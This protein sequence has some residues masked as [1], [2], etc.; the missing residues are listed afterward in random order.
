MFLQGE[1]VV[2]NCLLCTT[3]PYSM[4]LSWECAL[5]VSWG[6]DRT[7]EYRACRVS[8]GGPVVGVCAAFVARVQ[9]ELAVSPNG[10]P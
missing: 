5:R 1:L 8:A 6:T 3:E 10:E 2:N 7:C 9:K 4:R